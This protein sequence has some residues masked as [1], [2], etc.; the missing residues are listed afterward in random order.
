MH[1]NY[2]GAVCSCS[3]CAA[4]IADKAKSVPK[5][6]NKRHAFEIEKKV[7]HTPVLRVY[8]TLSDLVHDNCDSRKI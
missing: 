8:G 5:E 2:E 3:E 4:W 7:Y 1:L 6:Q